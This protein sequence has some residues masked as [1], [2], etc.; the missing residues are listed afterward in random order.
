MALVAVARLNAERQPDRACRPRGAVEKPGIAVE[1]AAVRR[2][3]C[4]PGEPARA[5]AVERG[6]AELRCRGEHRLEKVERL[7]RLADRVER[8]RRQERGGQR[9]AMAV[10]EGAGKPGVDVARPGKRHLDQADAIFLQ[11]IDLALDQRH[12]PLRRKREGM[13]AKR[14]HRRL[15]HVP[16][17][18][19]H[20]RDRCRRRCGRRPRSCWCSP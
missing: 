3:A 5:Q 1:L 16:R 11:Q 20:G 17:V 9:E 19:P 13:Q 7:L 15:S 18:R 10:G 4:D 12:V 6:A 8:A 14:A 2:T